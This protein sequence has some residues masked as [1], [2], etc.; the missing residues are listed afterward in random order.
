[1]VKNYLKI[2]VRSLLKNKVYAF[3]NIFGLTIGITCALL[4]FLYVQD[5]LTYDQNHKQADNI[6]RVGCEYFLPNDGGSEEWAPISGYVAQYFVQDY[7]E[8]LESVRFRKASNI[9]VQKEGSTNRF[10]QNI[11]YADS[12]VFKV[13]DVPLLKGD[14]ETALK[15]LTRYW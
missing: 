4:I 6:Y 1:M 12:N 10:Y 9:V 8:I 14:T 2:A 5:E 7:P 13:F 11:V 3:L 15:V